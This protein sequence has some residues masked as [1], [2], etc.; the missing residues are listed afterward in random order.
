MRAMA[1]KPSARY[2]TARELADDLRRFLEHEEVLAP[3]AP[4]HWHGTTWLVRYHRA[5]GCASLLIATAVFALAVN[6][7]PTEV[8]DP[9]ET[10]PARRQACE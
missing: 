3:R 8:N 9:V 10:R 5:L 4:L 2:A 1:R 6:R 7:Q